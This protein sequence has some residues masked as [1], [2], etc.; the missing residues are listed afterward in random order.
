M[1]DEPELPFYLWSDMVS[2]CGAELHATAK[3]YYA[4]TDKAKLATTSYQSMVCIWF[5]TAY[6]R[7]VANDVR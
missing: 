4:E 5:A 7:K 6:A 1:A 2:I 3:K